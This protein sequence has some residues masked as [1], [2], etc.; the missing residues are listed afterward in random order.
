MQIFAQHSLSLT[1]NSSLSAPLSS[2]RERLVHVPEQRK[3][4]PLHAISIK[5]LLHHSVS[6]AAHTS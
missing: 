1:A 2:W 3:C 4:V 6:Q 5:L